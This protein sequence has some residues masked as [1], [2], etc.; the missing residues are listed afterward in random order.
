MVSMNFLKTDCLIL[1]GS[2]G[3]VLIQR[4]DKTFMTTQLK[5]NEVYELLEELQHELGFVEVPQSNPGVCLVNL[6][7]VKYYRFINYLEKGVVNCEVFF[8]RGQSEYF[9][10]EFGDILCQHIPQKKL[11]DWTIK[12]GTLRNRK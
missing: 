9:C 3:S 5:N 12:K 10:E 11:P 6:S 2:L 7:V 1:I 8:G 4:L